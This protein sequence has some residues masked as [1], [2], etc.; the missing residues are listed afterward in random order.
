M[1]NKYYMPHI[2]DD[3]NIFGFMW[4]NFKFG[5]SFVIYMIL[6]QDIDWIF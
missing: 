5:Y 1:I 2:G 4:N 6:I 3:P